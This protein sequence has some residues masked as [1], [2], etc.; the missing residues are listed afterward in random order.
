MQ[1]GYYT[2]SATKTEDKITRWELSVNEAVYGEELS[3]CLNAVKYYS[4]TQPDI[5][6]M[7]MQIEKAV[8]YFVLMNF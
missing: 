6:D 1:A 5:K 7:R 3:K 2:I 4:I 8:K